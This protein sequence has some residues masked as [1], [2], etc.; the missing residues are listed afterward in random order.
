MDAKTTTRTHCRRGHELTEEN[1]Y[2]RPNGRRSCRTCR[3]SSKRRWANG[4]H[5]CVDPI[6][7][8][9]DLEL[10]WAAGFIDG[11]GCFTLIK[12]KDMADEYRR[13]HVTAVQVR[14]EPIDKLAEMFGGSV[15]WTGAAWQWCP[16]TKAM[17][18][19][20]PWLLP[21]FMVKR[22]EAEIVLAY[23]LTVRPGGRLSSSIRS[24]RLR[25]VESM[26]EIRPMR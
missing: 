3:R 23:A 17:V 10:A 21:Y 4:E 26:R 2:R 22:G 16:S 24:E 7:R 19:F 5:S 13:P 6:E 25:L 18:V 11:E 15:T 1:I 20:I 9:A 8:P 14:R 12:Q